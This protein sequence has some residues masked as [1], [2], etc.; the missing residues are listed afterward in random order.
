MKIIHYLLKL[1]PLSRILWNFIPNFLD[2]HFLR[3][4]K[5]GHDWHY[6]FGTQLVVTS[7]FRSNTLLAVEAAVVTS[8]HIGNLCHSVR[9][10]SDSHFQHT[11][12]WLRP[13]FSSKA[14][15]LFLLT[16]FFRFFLHYW[17]IVDWLSWANIIQ[18]YRIGNIRW[19]RFCKMPLVPF[20]VVVVDM[21][22][23]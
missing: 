8:I 3:Y 10:C 23:S 12:L 17:W 7:E 21:V 5:I 16:K 6:N 9:G 2:S 18:L 13:R 1:Y 15:I 22:I 19:G 11:T 4:H 14:D 20:V